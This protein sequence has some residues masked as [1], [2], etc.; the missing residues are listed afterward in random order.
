MDWKNQ[1]TKTP[2]LVLFIV[3]ITVG[4]GT[5]S[6]LI[7]ITLAGDVHITGDT[8]IDGELGVGTG[9]PNDDDKIWFD[10]GNEFLMWDDSQ[11]QFEFRDDIVTGDVIQSGNAGPNVAYNRI[12]IGNADSGFV[13]TNDD[14]YIKGDLE[15]DGGIHC[16][17]CILGRYTVFST[18]EFGDGGQLFLFADCDLGDI[19]TGGGFDVSPTDDVNPARS[20]PLGMDTWSVVFRDSHQL[21]EHRAVASCLDFPPAHVP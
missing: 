13:T 11:T 19:V 2:Y 3:L 9:N 8:T 14:L 12:G 16:P 10:D 5:A 6:A 21:V 15:I 7:T 18:G 4:V 20:H 17:N 1:L